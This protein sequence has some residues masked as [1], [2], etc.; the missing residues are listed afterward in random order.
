MLFSNTGLDGASLGAEDVIGERGN[1]LEVGD[2][3][4]SR[5]S[6]KSRCELLSD[7]RFCGDPKYNQTASNLI[8][9]GKWVPT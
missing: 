2:V 5:S 9:I 4:Y 1:F 6:S 3:D 7:A 8:L